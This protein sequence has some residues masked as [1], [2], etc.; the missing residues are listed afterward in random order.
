MVRH[1]PPRHLPQTNKA[2]SVTAAGGFLGFFLA[3][4]DYRTHPPR[5]TGTC[6]PHVP[7]HAFAQ[8]IGTGLEAGILAWIIPVGLGL[9]IGTIVGCLIALMIPVGRRR[10]G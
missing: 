4:K 5:A 7:T 6:H 1:R 3:L 8:C 2:Q 10:E 9:L